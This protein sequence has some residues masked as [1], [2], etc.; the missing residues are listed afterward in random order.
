TIAAAPL[1]CHGW[2]GP[3]YPLRKSLDR[4]HNRRSVVAITDTVTSRPARAKGPAVWLGMDQQE[5]DD[6]YDQSKDAPNRDQLPAR[7]ET[8]SAIARAAL[9]PPLRLA[10]GASKFEQLDVYRCKR[11]N[12]PVCVYVHGGAWR[13]GH[14]SEFAYLAELFVNAG[15]H[16]AIID[17]MNID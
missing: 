13:N 15:A 3:C 8:N 4:D 9:G 7:R 5:L 10:Y 11:P 14:A 17:F 6:A 2:A 16:C 1:P 12:A